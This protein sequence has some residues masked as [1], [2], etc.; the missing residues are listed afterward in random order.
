MTNP[1]EIDGSSYS[2]SGTIV[3]QAVALAALT[4]T[5]IRITNI[6]CRRPNPGL[7]PQHTRVVDAIRELVGGKAEGNEVGS[8]TLVFRP[9]KEVIR[10][11]YAWD[12]G[13]AGS[14]VLL[15]QALLPLL[16]F[17]RH[18]ATIQLRGGVFQDFAPSFYHLAHSLLPLLRRMGL[19]VDARMLKPGYVPVGEGVIELDVGLLHEP[20]KPLVLEDRGDVRRVWGVAFASHLKERQVA[21]RMADA[22]RARLEQAGFVPEIEEIDDET[23]AQPGAACAV[24]ADVAN[25]AC[26]GADRAG[27]P[28]RRAEVVGDYAARALLEDLRTGASIDRFA[29]DQLIIFAALA[30]GESR[31]RIPRLTDHIEADA[32]LARQL[33]GAEV[34]VLDGELRAHGVGFGPRR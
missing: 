21:R 13:S 24:F 34:T 33:L 5:D 17:H 26:L 8:S 10:G 32:W 27:A 22:A 3:R 16:A 6:R 11:R 2:G 25:G 15:A 23:A 18:E 7:R 4:A 19:T 20:L 30:G 12:I 1:Q 28:R 31:W 14:T 9:G 29:A